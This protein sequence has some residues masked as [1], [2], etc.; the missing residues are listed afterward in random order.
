[1]IGLWLDRFDSR[2]GI[3]GGTALVSARR[4]SGQDMGF[5]STIAALAVPE[6]V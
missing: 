6:L 5:S 2:T 4:R 3:F 1:M